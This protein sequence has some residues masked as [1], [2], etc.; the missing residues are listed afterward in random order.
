MSWKMIALAFEKEEGKKK[1]NMA[2]LSGLP[3]QTLNT[4]PNPPLTCPSLPRVVPAVGVRAAT[5]QE[6]FMMTS[7]KRSISRARLPAIHGANARTRSGQSCNWYEKWLFKLRDVEAALVRRMVMERL[8]AI[9]TRHHRKSWLAQW[10]LHRGTVSF[11]S[12]SG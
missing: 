8:A 12:L 2:G 9:K 4:C 7:A 5:V 11:A 1:K 6:K 10:K 3:P